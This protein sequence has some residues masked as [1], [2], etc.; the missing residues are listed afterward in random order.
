MTR[1]IG[2]MSSR[3]GYIKISDTSKIFFTSDTHFGHTRIIDYVSRPFSGGVEEMDRIM[4]ERWN[5]VVP[6]DGVVFHLGDFAFH[7]AI[8][9]RDI[10]SSLHGRK[11]LVVGNHDHRTL[12]VDAWSEVHSQLL[13]KIGEIKVYLNHFPFRSW[14]YHDGKCLQLHGHLHSGPTEVLGLPGQL[15]VGVDGHDYRP[16][17]WAEIEDKIKEGY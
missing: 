4:I 1:R 6:E 7:G 11:I 8:K 15:D 9:Y 2:G 10:A 13:L 12:K 3:K 16:W 17:T 5:E 14:P